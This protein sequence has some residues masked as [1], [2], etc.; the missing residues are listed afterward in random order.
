LLRSYTPKKALLS[1]KDFVIKSPPRQDQGSSSGATAAP[2]TPGTGNGTA[3]G[4]VARKGNVMTN[5]DAM[6]DGNVM[7]DDNALTNG[8]ESTDGDIKLE[9][10]CQGIQSDKIDQFEN[11]DLSYLLKYWDK[12]CGFW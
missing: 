7:L 8:N 6:T 2:V 9:Y 1:T 4:S 3:E 10:E 11:V 5:G 12:F